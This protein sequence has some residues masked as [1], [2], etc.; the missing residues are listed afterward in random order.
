MKRPFEMHRARSVFGLFGGIVVLWIILFLV[1]RG[2]NENIDTIRT[3]S[4]PY[5]D[6]V[7]VKPGSG[8]FFTWGVT[9]SPRVKVI[10]ATGTDDRYGD[11]YEQAVNVMRTLSDDLAEVG[12]TLR[13]VVNVRA[14]LVADPE[15]DYEGW[16]RAFSQ[17]F[18]TVSNPHKPARTTVGITRLFLSSYRIE[19][20]F[21]CAIPQGRGPMAEGTRYFDR[22]ERLERAETSTRFASFGRPAWPM[23]TGKAT[24]PGSSLFFS[25]SLRPRSLLPNAPPGMYFFGDISKQSE[26][27]F[28]QMGEGLSAAG[29]GYGDVFFL[30]T[31][32]YPDLNTGEIGSAFGQFN[33]VYNEYFNNARNPNRPTRTVMSAPGYARQ[34]QSVSVEIYAVHPA[35]GVPGQGEAAGLLRVGESPAAGGSG[36]IAPAGVTVPAN[37]ATIWASGVVSS[38]GG[39]M[40]AQARSALEALRERLEAAGSSLDRVVQ[41]RAYLVDSPAIQNDIAAWEQVFASSFGD[42]PGMRPALTTLPVVS[43]PGGGKIEVEA[44]AAR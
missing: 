34:R 30:R 2:S 26:S 28:A 8:Y 37:M 21:I 42:T 41:V 24:E 9:A 35:S 15:A 13:D 1:A 33:Q 36:P 25:S 31:V 44:M 29:L 19:V 14:Y 23:S 40:A 22:Y 11:T 3:G 10:A 38:V 12:L 6:S 32:V 43:V 17:F 20:E 4:R 5:A 27:I 7:T 18:G 16:N 39:D